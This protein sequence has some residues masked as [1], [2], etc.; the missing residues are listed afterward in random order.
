MGRRLCSIVLSCLVFFTGGCM[1]N[2]Q[3]NFVKGAVNPNKK[4]TGADRYF[5]SLFE[6]DIGEVFKKA[7]DYF[8][9]KGYNSDFNMRYA[10]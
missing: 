3:A 10:E 4:E 8:I 9:G 2:G 5:R 7:G 1:T 6:R